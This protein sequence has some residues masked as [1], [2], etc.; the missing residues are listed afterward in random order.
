MSALAVKK[1]AGAPPG[2]RTRVEG[3][4]GPNAG[5]TTPAARCHGIICS[6]IFL[7]V[8]CALNISLGG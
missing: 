3:L 2:I 6:M 4:E 7:F 8:G 5:P 1:G